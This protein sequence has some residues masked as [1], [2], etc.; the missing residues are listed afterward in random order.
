MK[1]CHFFVALVLS[2]TGNQ[3]LSKNIEMRWNGSTKREP[4]SCFFTHFAW[5]SD[6]LLN[7]ASVTVQ[8]PLE[9]QRWKQNVRKYDIGSRLVLPFHDFWGSKRFSYA[10]YG[11][12]WFP[13][14]KRP[15]S[16]PKKNSTRYMIDTIIAFN[17]VTPVLR[18]PPHLASSAFHA[19][20]PEIRK[21]QCRLTRARPDR[22]RDRSTPRC[23]IAELRAAPGISN[24]PGEL[25]R[26]P[27][28]HIDGPGVL[29]RAQTAISTAQECFF[30]PKRP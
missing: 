10:T 3:F 26:I 2:F 14:P 9:N 5:N 15:I 13:R 24:P 30:G 19:N 29:L 18:R 27:N 21:S 23:W 1:T 7:S 20:N 17:S 6:V 11:G 25:I 16:F 4:M 12:C 28:G 8:I 22:W